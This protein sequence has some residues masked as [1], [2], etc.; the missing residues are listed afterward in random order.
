[1]TT[2]ELASLVCS[3]NL[4]SIPQ[5][6]I[7][8][9]KNSLLNYM[10]VAIG[11]S[12][13][14]MIDMLLDVTHE[15][16]RNQEAQVLGRPERVDIY[17]ASMANGM[18]AHIFDYDDTLLDTVLHPSAPVFPAL[19]AYAEK[20]EVSGRDMLAA[21]VL[22]VEVSQRIGQVVYPSSYDKG[23]HM[24]G[25]VGQF[26][27]AVSVGCLMGLSTEQMQHALGI[28]AT[29]PVG[30]REMFGTYT[31]PFH[32]GRASANGLLAALLAQKGFTSSTQSLEALRGFLRVTSE[33]TDFSRL[34]SEWGA[35][36]EIMK[37]SYKPF[38]CGIV[39]HPAIDAAVNLHKKGVSADNVERIEI[40][41]NPLVL[42]LTG[43]K[44]PRDGLEAKFSVF[45]CVAAGLLD[46]W[47]GLVQF[48]DSR[49]TAEDVVEMRS[50]VHATIDTGIAEDQVRVK[51]YEKC[52]KVHELFIEH[53]I[54]SIENPMTKEQLVQKFVGA[55]QGILDR[56]HQE[57]L[58]E[59]T[60][61]LDKAASLKNLVSICAASE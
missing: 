21:F 48:E 11:A 4:S 50:R 49:V 27:A 18:S 33:A 57:N 3:T 43:K 12:R 45:H 16:G 17:T 25:H 2:S 35:N 1:V 46:G 41:V 53:A 26:G 8:E 28:A 54:G 20:H 39:I 7:E 24:T 13:H 42:E 36:W 9:A 19:M 51:A 22:G 10:G 32:P 44:T 59:E 55:T 34:T 30:L 23:W 29:Q 15:W 37:N 14:A 52:G 5:P 58:I 60:W 6:A 40:E 56:A 61:N 47:V 31:K 38:P